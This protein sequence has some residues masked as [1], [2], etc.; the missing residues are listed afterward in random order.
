MFNDIIK[1]ILEWR[2]AT[3]AFEVN[4][5]KFGNRERADKL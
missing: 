3:S 4:V 1:K 5:M 2:L